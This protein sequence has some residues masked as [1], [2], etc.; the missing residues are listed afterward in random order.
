MVDYNDQQADHEN[1]PFAVRVII[2]VG[3]GTMGVLNVLDRLNY[4]ISGSVIDIER[5]IFDA[6][7]KDGIEGVV[8]TSEAYDALGEYR[9]RYPLKAIQLKFK[10]DVE[11]DHL[12]YKFR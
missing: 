11:K 8:I 7:R 10:E 12:L 2:H 6:A 1:P 4:S 3:P 9:M 5:M